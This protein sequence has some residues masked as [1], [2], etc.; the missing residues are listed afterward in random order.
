M[1]KEW[2]KNEERRATFRNTCIEEPRDKLLETETNA[3]I[4]MILI[5]TT[6]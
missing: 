2:E 5:T 3:I 4:M 1:R 6:N